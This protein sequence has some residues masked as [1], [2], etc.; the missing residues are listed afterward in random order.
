MKQRSEVKIDC[1]RGKE[2]E[3]WPDARKDGGG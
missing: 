1:W 2:S 3:D